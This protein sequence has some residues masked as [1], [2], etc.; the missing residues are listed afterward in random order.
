M[1]SHFANAPVELPVTGQALRQAL[2]ARD[3]SALLACT[4][5]LRV[6]GYRVEPG[7]LAAELLAHGCSWVEDAF[8]HRVS[9]Q[10]HVPKALAQLQPDESCSFRIAA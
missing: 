1:T 7:R 2:E 4:Q 3:V 8:G 9:L 5:Q 6:A 10:V